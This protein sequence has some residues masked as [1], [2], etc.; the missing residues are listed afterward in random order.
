MKLNKPGACVYCIVNMILAKLCVYVYFAG[1]MI[2]NCGIWNCP[3]L[4]NSDLQNSNSTW[5]P[6]W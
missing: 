5:A 4:A 2:L 1:H 6:V 3:Y